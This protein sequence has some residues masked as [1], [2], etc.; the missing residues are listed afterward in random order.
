MST[1]QKTPR[2]WTF[3]R[4]VVTATLAFLGAAAIVAIAVGG[5]L[6]VVWV[7]SR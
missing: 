1:P 7:A 4:I 2:P 6:V 3:R 5:C